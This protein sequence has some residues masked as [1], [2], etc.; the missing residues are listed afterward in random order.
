MN[1]L[2]LID[3]KIKAFVEVKKKRM[4]ENE[5]KLKTLKEEITLY[6]CFYETTYIKAQLSFN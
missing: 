1:P 4:V 6:G 5:Y 3:E 2:L